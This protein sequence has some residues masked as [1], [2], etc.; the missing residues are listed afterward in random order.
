MGIFAF[1]VSLDLRG[2]GGS[3]PSPLGVPA[4]EAE[5]LPCGEVAGEDWYAGAPSQCG[6][7]GSGNGSLQGPYATEKEVIKRKRKCGGEMSSK[8]HH[9][10]VRQVEI[11]TSLDKQ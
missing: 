5:I 9:W 4:E 2:A 8:L 11:G 1:P 6:T 7:H 10:N 3:L